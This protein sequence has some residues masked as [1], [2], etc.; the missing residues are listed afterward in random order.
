MCL[1]W[2]WY[3]TKNAEVI[4]K[5]IHRH[6]TDIHLQLVQVIIYFIYSFVSSAK[7]LIEN[8]EKKSKKHT[9]TQKK[10]YSHALLVLERQRRAVSF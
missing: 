9:H 8:E 3:S 5:K 2:Y 1:Y 10:V 4:T 7:A 6:S